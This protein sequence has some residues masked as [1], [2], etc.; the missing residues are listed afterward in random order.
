VIMLRSKL[1]IKLRIANFVP[2]TMSTLVALS[3]S[4]LPV[5][6]AAA[7]SEGSEPPPGV[8]QP[9]PQEAPAEISIE[10]ERQTALAKQ[11]MTIS[12]TPDAGPQSKRVSVVVGLGASV[13]PAY[14]GSDVTKVS[15]LPYVDVRGLLDGRLYISDVSGLGLNLVDTGSFRA[16]LNTNVA[17]GRDSSSDAHLRG[18]PGIDKATS[19]GGFMA[20]RSE[21]F[22]FQATVA[23]RVGSHP[24][25]AASLGTTYSV[26]PLPNFQLTASTS[27]NWADASSLN[28]F[29]GI[30]PEEA[31]HAAAVGNPLPP[32]S[33]RGG[34]F[35][36]AATFAAVY[37]LGDHWGLVGRVGLVDLIGNSVNDSPLTQRSF[38]P[39]AQI[40]LLYVF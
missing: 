30:S 3:L 14:A 26:S 15:P 31:A 11:T 5:A 1:I 33:P 38:Q 20:Y 22:A 21:P 40:G 17:G 29:F 10:A 25:T 16:G 2:F 23:R 18:L 35:N 36:V 19:I 27:V 7:Q 37:M 32:Y 6:L 8:Q 4:R 24:G 13:G 12:E 39:N 9:D 28:T 34:V